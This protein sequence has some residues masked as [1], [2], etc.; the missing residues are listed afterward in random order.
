MAEL[1]FLFVGQLLDQLK[2]VSAL[3]YPR[4][5]RCSTVG[6]SVLCFL[7]FLFPFYTLSHTRSLVL[8]CFADVFPTIKQCFK[9][10]VLCFLLLFGCGRIW[11]NVISNTFP[12][13]LKENR[14][15]NN[16]KN[17]ADLSSSSTQLYVDRSVKT[18]LKSF[19]W[20]LQIKI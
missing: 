3:H 6:K 19:Y 13:N 7:L 8:L 16:W 9:I 2:H 5:H 12:Q 1:C 20:F 11:P 18:R 14:G 15:L 17:D 10:K 4:A